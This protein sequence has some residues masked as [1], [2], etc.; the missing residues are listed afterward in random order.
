MEIIT[1]KLLIEPDFALVTLGDS[2]H[3]GRYLE[4][5]HPVK[6]SLKSYYWL[7]QQVQDLKEGQVFEVAQSE[8]IVLHFNPNGGLPLATF[9]DIKANDLYNWQFCFHAPLVLLDLLVDLWRG[10]EQLFLLGWE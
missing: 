6:E 9:Q 3:L 1:S 5:S 2:H 7:L 4:R 10:D 8:G